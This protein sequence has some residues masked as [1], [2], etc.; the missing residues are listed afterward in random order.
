MKLT[1]SQLRKIIKEEIGKRFLRE[2]YE[3]EY[4]DPDSDFYDAE[5]I[6]RRIQD[7]QNAEP[8]MQELWA[9]YQLHDL[10][11]SAKK[12][13]MRRIPRISAADALMNEK[14]INPDNYSTYQEFKDDIFEMDRDYNTGIVDGLNDILVDYPMT[15]SRRRR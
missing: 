10:K 4:E 11:D 14:G 3:D 1:V 15:E 9:Y 6:E 13:Q 12:S 8:L 2:G 5:E 7:R